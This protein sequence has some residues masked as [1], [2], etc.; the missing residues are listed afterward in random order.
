MSRTVIITTTAAPGRPSLRLGMTV[1]DARAARMVGANPGGNY[2]AKKPAAKAKA[3]AKAATTASVDARANSFLAR[4]EL[5]DR[6]VASGVIQ[7]GMRP[8][9]AQAYDAD[10]EGCRAFLAKLPGGAAV[11]AATVVAE[12]D[13]MSLLTDA[14]RENV[15]N[16]RAGRRPRF[17]NGG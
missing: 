2:K 4:E 1:D 11:A 10:A 17:V 14:E 5:L 15:A 16:A 13:G 8:H 9:Y 12:D 3:K 7:D 6:A